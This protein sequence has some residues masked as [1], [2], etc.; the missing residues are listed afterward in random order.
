MSSSFQNISNLSHFERIY[1]LSMVVILSREHNTKINFVRKSWADKRRKRKYVN[2]PLLRRIGEMEVKLP[3]FL[4][5]APYG[6]KMSVSSS[7]LCLNISN[8]E[9]PQYAFLVYSILHCESITAYSASC[10]RTP[11]ASS[12]SKRDQLEKGTYRT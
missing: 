4:T 7:T 12:N 2:S 5:P 9:S 1:R 6:S 10:N 8:F 3:G 11:D